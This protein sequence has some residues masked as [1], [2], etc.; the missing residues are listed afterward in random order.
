MEL[1]VRYIDTSAFAYHLVASGKR[2]H[3]IPPR[4]APKIACSSRSEILRSVFV[5]W[6]YRG[7]I[8]NRYIEN[9]DI[10]TWSK[11]ADGFAYGFLGFASNVLSDNFSFSGLQ[12]PVGYTRSSAASCSAVRP[13]KAETWSAAIPDAS[14]FLAT[15]ALPLASPSA[16]PAA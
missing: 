5:L 14:R 12:N 9:P 2:P 8:L 16:S 4:T 13:V 3:R 1:R 10:G 11:S 7:N 6:H 15:S